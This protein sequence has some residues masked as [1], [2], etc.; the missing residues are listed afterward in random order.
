MSTEELI[1][2][3]I[4]SKDRGVDGIWYI[5]ALQDPRDNRVRYVGKTSG[6]ID[7][8]VRSHLKEAT[9]SKSHTHRLHWL[10]SL[11][12]A[13]L[14][15]AVI[16]LEEGAG[17]SWQ[18]AEKKWIKEY[19]NRGASLVNGTEGGD[20]LST[21]TKELRE[22]IASKLRGRK[23][24]PRSAIWRE[25]LSAAQK[26]KKKSA[27]ARAKMSTAKLGKHFSPEHRAKIAEG[28]RGKKVVH[29]PEWCR[30]HSETLRGRKLSEEQRARISAGLMGHIIS[31]ETRLKIGMSNKGR[32]PSDEARQKSSLSHKGHHLSAET[33]AKLSVAMKAY[34]ASQKHEQSPTV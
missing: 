21:A 34:R 7:E 4:K 25:R 26:G 10:K 11:L 22:R 9:Y 6:K 16:I 2:D 20:G 8:R 24:P 15:P 3:A 19:R 30:H 12:A 17:T 1:L 18:D 5:Y 27:E 29:S 28:N 14:S 33:R 13:N 31:A 23:L 32:K